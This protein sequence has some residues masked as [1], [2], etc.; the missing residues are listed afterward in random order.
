MHVHLTGGA[1]DVRIDLETL[2]TMGRW[3]SGLK[4]EVLEWIVAHRRELIE[5]WK[6]WHA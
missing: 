1:F 4:A 2:E 5:E 3:P 6:K